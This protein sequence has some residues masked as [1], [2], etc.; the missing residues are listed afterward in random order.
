MRCLSESAPLAEVCSQR[1]FGTIDERS[2]YQIEADVDEA[3]DGLCIG[4]IRDE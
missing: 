4:A 1:M 3:S 2:T